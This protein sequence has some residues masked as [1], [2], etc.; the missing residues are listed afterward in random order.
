MM[1]PVGDPFG[2]PA[3][4]EKNTGAEI[5]LVA[6]AAVSAVGA[7][8]QAAAASNA[9][10]F[11]ATIAQQNADIARQQGAADQERQKRLA[12]KAL[13][14]ITAGYGASGVSMEGSPLDVLAESARQAELDYQTIGYNAELKAMGYT[15]TATLEQYKGQAAETAGYLQAGSSLL[16][17]A[18]NVNYG[19]SGGLD[20]SQTNVYDAAYG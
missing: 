12:I 18:S 8:S 11:N 7:I 9:A 10:D 13:G 15:N 19:T 3:Y 2:G 17:A 16:G 4:G 1:E 6:A 14:D 5:F 20:Y